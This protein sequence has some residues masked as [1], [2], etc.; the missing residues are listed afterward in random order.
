MGCGG[1]LATAIVAMA[2]SFVGGGFLWE[3]KS[4]FGRET[5][6]RKEYFGLGLDNGVEITAVIVEK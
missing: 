4:L 1:W 3:K 2:L 5:V 6:K